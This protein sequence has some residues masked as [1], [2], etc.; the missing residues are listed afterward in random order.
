M[1]FRK[2]LGFNY[3]RTRY[4]EKPIQNHAYM[5]DVA[6]CDIKSENFLQ[7]SQIAIPFRKFP[8]WRFLIRQREFRKPHDLAA[9]QGRFVGQDPDAGNI[10]R[11]AGVREGGTAFG[12]G[13]YEFVYQV[14]M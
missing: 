4:F 2:P 5:L 3:T 12:Q 14:G 11:L 1:H 10:R 13:A 7:L 6:I 9:F 8:V